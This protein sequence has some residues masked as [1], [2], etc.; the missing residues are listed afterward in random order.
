MK[1]YTYS[2]QNGLCRGREAGR[3][4]APSSVRVGAYRIRPPNIPQGM[5]DHTRGR[6]FATDGGA[7]R[8]YSIRPYPT[9]RRAFQYPANLA[10]VP[11]ASE[12]VKQVVSRF[13]RPRKCPNKLFQG[14]RGLGKAQT[15]CFKESEASE[16]LKQV[17]SR[18]PTRRKGPNRL[19]QGFRRVG[20]LKQ[21]V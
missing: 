19:F 16:R 14:F 15:G 2:Y 4:P 7:W 20:R 10:G 12:S 3:I 18:F 17:V 1:T 6:V 9:G 5:N 8:A 21:V 13:P 11:D